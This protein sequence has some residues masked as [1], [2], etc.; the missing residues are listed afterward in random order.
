MEVFD[1]IV[2][3]VQRSMM[4]RLAVVSSSLRRV[5][6]PLLFDDGRR[7]RRPVRRSIRAA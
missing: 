3:S 7:C 4:R 6:W 5:P 2:G 1:R